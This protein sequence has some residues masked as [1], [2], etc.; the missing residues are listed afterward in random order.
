VD[1]EL[2]FVGGMNIGGKYADWLDL[3]LATSNKKLVRHIM[4]SFAK[5]YERT[6][7]R[8]KSVLRW[9]R[10]PQTPARPS[11]TKQWFIEHW[12]LRG[13][14]ALRDY[15]RAA[16]A[17]ASKRITIVTPYFIPHRWLTESLLNATRRGVKTEVI[18]PMKT[19]VWFAN[20]ANHAF[21]ETLGKNIR[22]YFVP[23]MI[24]AKI[25]IIDNREGLIGSN[26]ID[27]Q[28]FDFNLEAGVRF[29][30]RDMVGDLRRIVSK[31]QHHALPA[32]TVRTTL[33]WYYHIFAPII[34][35]FQP[36]L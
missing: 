36:V 17:A 3:N 12:P 6:G 20:V 5:V 16:C 28:S 9:K 13:K 35:F 30:R 26:N 27:A 29:Q 33:P 22:F 23:E 11:R 7:G 32:E 21:A 24:H 14:S 15:Y 19:D 25:L 1:G 31:W 18:L 4:N 10:K 2:A 34:K 8:D